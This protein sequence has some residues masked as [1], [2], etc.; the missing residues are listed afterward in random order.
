M[1][2][3]INVNEPNEIELAFNDG[4]TVV[5][6][7]DMMAIARFNDLPDG[8]MSYVNEKSKA[9]QCAMVIYVGAALYNPE[10]TLDDARKIVSRMDVGTV[11]EIMLEFSASMGSA[12]KQSLDELQKKT[13]QEFLNK[14]K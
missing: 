7:Y 8:I 11:N 1:R 13:M 6:T 9:E 12:N 14:L 4:K 3:T 5:L 2:K 10:I